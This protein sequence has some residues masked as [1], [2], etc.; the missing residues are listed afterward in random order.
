ML[1]EYQKEGIKRLV[2]GS[3]I[4]ADD[5]GLGKT[6]QAV[7]AIESFR[8]RFGKV[9]VLVVCPLTLQS[10]WLKHLA[11]WCDQIP[12]IVTSTGRFIKNGV[13]ITHYE[14]LSKLKEGAWDIIIVDE[15]HKIKNRK[16]KRTKAVTAITKDAGFV[17]LLTGTPIMNK[18]EEVWTLLHIIDRELYGS[19]WKFVQTWGTVRQGRYGWIVEKEPRNPAL[20]ALELKPYVVRRTKEEVLPQLPTLSKVVIDTPMTARQEELHKKFLEEFKAEVGEEIIY[21][22]YVISQLLRTRQV[23]ISPQLLGDEDIGNKIPVV[24]DMIEGGNES[25]IVIFSQ[26]TSVL[27]LL[28]QHLSNCHILCGEVPVD[29][30]DD[31][32]TKWREKGGNLLLTLGVG[33]VGLTLTEASVCIRMD[34]AWTPSDNDQAVARIHRIGQTKPAMDYLIRSENSVEDYVKDVLGGKDRMIKAIMERIK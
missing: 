23:A 10:V 6:V 2:R 34:E 24:L 15:A 32:I 21:A 11:E 17:W 20:F 12:F 29:K 18:V 13:T 7:Y 22:P 9:K 33:G 30:R 8:R 3:I 1:R 5:M 14:A 25:H 4:L 31:V 28:A 27:K 26:W 19:Y 16:A